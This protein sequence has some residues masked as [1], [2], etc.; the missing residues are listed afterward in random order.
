MKITS[1]KKSKYGTPV[2]QRF[3]VAIMGKCPNMKEKKFPNFETKK[4]FSVSEN[5]FGDD[6]RL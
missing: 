4:S 2:I 3:K 6:P 5:I 1:K